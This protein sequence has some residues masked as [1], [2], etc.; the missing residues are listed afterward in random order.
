MDVQYAMMKNVKLI[1]PAD[2]KTQTGAYPPLGLGYINAFLK[3]KHVACDVI[4]LSFDNNLSQIEKI[5]DKN[6][7]YG[8]TCSTS[9]Y[10]LVKKIAAIIKKNDPE[11]IICIGGAHPTAVPELI[12]KDD[13]N[14]DV[15]VIGEGEYTMYDI[16]K[17][18]H[19]NPN[20]IKGIYYRNN[21]N[22][23]KTDNRIPIEILDD[24]PFPAQSI[25][26]IE[27][28]FSKKG[29]REL[30]MITSRG[31]PNDC[32][33]CQPVL[34]KMFGKKTRFR[35]AKNVVDEIEYLVKTLNL[36]IIVFSDDTFTLS[37]QHTIDVCQEIIKRRLNI[38]WR[39]QTRVTTDEETV[40]IMKKAGCF[41]MA[42]GVES[43]SEIILKNI[44]KRIT[45]KQIIKVFDIGKTMG[46]LTYAFIMVGNDGEN[47]QT[48]NQTIALVKRI[49]PYS[50]HVGIITP[51][52]GTHIYNSLKIINN[53]W[54]K[55]VH[56]ED[57][58]IL[59]NISVL[60]PEEILKSKHDIENSFNKLSKIKD[61]INLLKDGIILKIIIKKS[62]K[63][64]GFFIR[65][66]KLLLNSIRKQGFKIINPRYKI[67]VDK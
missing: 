34:H 31:C 29:Y 9:F 39:V 23:I 65:S 2:I 35:S 27:K 4:D 52:P 7:I 58:T 59:F 48:I 41:L 20:L 63:D 10:P 37:K 54:A 15:I 40:R 33:F 1:L 3:S 26:P 8:I 24:L 64:R 45:L 49:K 25:F 28:Y 60:T 62:I 43:G 38:L 16:V 44:R 51:Y 13:K 55:Y 17:F 22:I 53:N 50:G 18:Y 32:V 6:I 56:V 47:K 14:I 42:F 5:K 12:L 67:Q 30:S 61:I 57:K 21:N 19:E 46:V 66:A 36:D 11:S